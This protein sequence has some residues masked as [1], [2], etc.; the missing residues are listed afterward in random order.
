MRAPTLLVCLLAQTI[1]FTNVNVVPMTE[2]RVLRDQVVL[3]EGERIRAIGAA[4]SVAIPEDARRIDGEGGYL[5]PG[6][7]DLHAHVE[8]G[9][10]PLY[11]LNGVTTVLLAGDGF[12]GLE[13]REQAKSGAL[14]PGIVACGPYM[15]DVRDPAAAK[16][17]VE[18]QKRDGY[19]C[20]KIYDDID[21]AALPVLVN[22]AREL[23]LLSIGHIP[24]NLTWQQMLTAK[25]DAIAHLEEFL[26]SPVDIGDDHII[27][28]QM[29]QNDIAVIT[30]LN[31]YDVITRQVADLETQLDRGE[32]RYMSPMFTRTWE[33]PYNTRHRN[34]K[35]SA[36]ANLR[37]LLA[38]QKGLGKKLH[39]AGGRV[40]M[41]TDGGG[42]PFVFPGWSA[43]DELRQLVSMGMTPY[44]ALR[45]A[46]ANGAKFLR[47]ED[48]GTIEAGKTADL[49][50]LRGDPLRDIGNVDLRMGVML[51]GRWLDQEAI[52]A[53]LERTAATNDLE[54]EMLRIL[55][56][57]GID[58]ALRFAR[59]QVLPER[60]LIELGYFHLKVKKD[61]PAA[62]KLFRFVAEQHPRS[63]NA[64]DS[65]GEALLAAGDRAG[66]LASYRKA[67]E[68]EP[69]NRAAQKAIDELTP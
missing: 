16:R 15:T 34:I 5:I 12:P 19:D 24:R 44:D 55:G 36:V 1:A 17:L 18:E 32:V 45:A 3:V 66:A 50:L 37:R 43:S 11:A 40:L 13:M 48:I 23:G 60:D 42:P 21:V 20:I 56:A 33:V 69:R 63:W 52:R 31:C 22:S 2:N 30:T 65:L 29:V 7:I 51:R 57:S 4:D 49:V 28:G 64:H 59:T 53:L 68:L 35:R 54:H 61:V 41:G 47:R 9:G 26:Y 46:T 67:L 10:M 38:F 39:D 25:P 27:V 62:V 8:H 6:L 14:L 58:A